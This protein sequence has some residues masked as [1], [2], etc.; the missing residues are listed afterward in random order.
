MTTLRAL[1][2]A[3]LLPL[4]A[5]ASA[6]AAAPAD[7]PAGGVPVSDG[8]RAS[9]Y[10]SEEMDYWL[11]KGVDDIYRMRFDEAEA[12]AR[13]AI[14]LDPA[15]PN[16]YM[17]LAGVTWTKYVYGTDQG[18]PKLL[19]LFGQQIKQAI[20]VGEDWVKAHPDDPE[21][22]MTL[23]AAYGL[24]SRLDIIRHQWVRG[25]L[26]GRKAVG[27]TRQSVQKDPQLWDGWLGVGM[28]D[29]YTDVYPRFIGVLAK[30]VLRGNRLR[31]IETLKQVAEKGHFSK[32]NARIL[33]VEI[34]LEDQW[35]AR[36]PE[37]AMA[38]L[39]ALRAQYPESAMM[40]SADMVA[41][42]EGKRYAEVLTEARAYLQ[43]VAR[44]EYRP[45]E[46]AKGNVA[47]GCALWQLGHRDEALEAFK[48]AEDVMFDGKPSR[49]S[50]WAHIRA[51]QLLDVMGRRADALAEYKFA[52]AQPDTW[53]FKQF[54]KAGLAKPFAQALPGPIDPP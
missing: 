41:R 21:G 18:D 34:Y 42:Y 10:I 35:G 40:H 38:L 20:S 48:R 49:W 44:G 36:D 27:I 3:T 2:L 54:A 47:L 32:N 29:Y 22:L 9:K 31:G 53:D 1:L 46:A 14:A 52:A 33:L 17:G 19:D 16:A 30:L 39:R 6:L 13:K 7:M 24:S 50:V 37:K 26:E 12:A 28:Y 15:H 11:M 4:S 25:Y 5:G 45:I 51:G 8:P 43:R 23:G